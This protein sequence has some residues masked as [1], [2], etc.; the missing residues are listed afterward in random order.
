PLVHQDLGDG[1]LQLGRGDVHVGVAGLLG[2]ADAGEVVRDGVGDRA[3]DAS[4]AS[5]EGRTRAGTTWPLE[6]KG[7]RPVAYQLDLR[8]P[9]I[10]PS[11]AIS[12]KTTR[13]TPNFRIYPRGRPVRAQRLWRRTGLASRGSFWS[14][15]HFPSARRRRR[16]SAYFATVRRRWASLAMSALRAI[17]SWFGQVQAGPQAGPQAATG[18]SCSRR[19]N[20][21]PSSF[22]SAYASSSVGAVVT[23]VTSRPETRSIL[24]MSIS[25][26]MICSFTPS[27]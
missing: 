13:Q 7:E 16:F 25:G 15:S 3:H 24:S 5:L 6:I 10:L 27:V 14:S 19:T 22:R 12:R 23:M 18:S 8:T 17:G 26:K 1:A 21:I 9:G 11:S 20:G 4:S 2:V